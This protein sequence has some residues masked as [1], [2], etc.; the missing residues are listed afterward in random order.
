MTCRQLALLVRWGVVAE[1][2][3]QT[4]RLIRTNRFDGICPWHAEHCQAPLLNG[5]HD[6]FNSLPNA[7]FSEREVHKRPSNS[8]MQKR[9]RSI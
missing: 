6:R 2:P 4:V 8:D 3:T 1:R 5:L 7:H 9:M